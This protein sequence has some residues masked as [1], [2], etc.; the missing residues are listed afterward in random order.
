MFLGCIGLAPAQQEIEVNTY[1]T[2]WGEKPIP[3]TVS[4]YSGEVAQVLRYDLEVQGFKVVSD[5][6]AQFDVTG[7]NN[8]NVQGRV[9]DRI[10]K[11]QKLAKAYSGGSLRAQAHAFADDIVQAITGRRGIGQTKIAFKVD[12]GAASEIYV[13]DF[14][15]HNANPVTQDG[16]IVAAPSWVPGHMGLYY[17]SYKFGGANIMAHNLTTGARSVFAHYGGSNLSPA[18]SP[19]GSRVAMVLSKDGWVDLYVGNTDGTGLKRLTKSQQDES[20]PCWSPDGKWILFAGKDGERRVLRKVSADGGSVHNVRTAGAP[21]PSEP[22]WS[23]DGK[24]IVFTTQRGNGFD[25]CIVPAGGGDAI[26]LV[27]GEDPSWS[28]NSR[29]VVFARRSG[30]GRI[31]SVLDVFT[32]QV[33]DVARISGSN[34]QPSWAK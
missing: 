3:L 23:P 34:S 14:D 1:A 12:T 16:S 32:K 15:G 8:D 7:G 4:G 13:A 20:S 31:L 11:Q 26:P 33:K 27:E 22:D 10:A 9:T 25:I 28:P 5:D 21:S 19:D 24:W 18:V 2:G 29:T 30:N 6:T 17:M